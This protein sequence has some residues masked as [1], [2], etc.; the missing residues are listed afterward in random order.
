MK[1]KMKKI[2]TFI[3]AIAMILSFQ[4]SAFADEL[5]VNA[6]QTET[7]T[8]EE[9]EL[10]VLADSITGTFPIKDGYELATIRYYTDAAK[11]SYAF[12]DFTESASGYAYSFTAPYSGFSK[13]E[14]VETKDSAPS[15][16]ATVIAYYYSTT[17]WDGAVDVSWY[18]PDA[19]EYYITNPAEFA[20]VAAIVN[21]SLDVSVK[22]YMVKGERISDSEKNPDYTYRFDMKYIVSQW[23]ENQSAAAGKTNDVYMGLA[24]NDFSDKV[25]Y[26]TENLDMGGK[27]GDEFNISFDEEKYTRLDESL[28]NWMPIGGFF[29]ADIKDTRTQVRAYFNGQFDG[30]GHSIDNLYCFRWNPWY[31]GMNYAA[32]VK[33]EDEFCAYGY[34]EGVGLFGTIASLYDNEETPTIAP[35][36]RNL[37]LS[38]LTT[39]RRRQGAIIGCVNGYDADA[40]VC[41]ENCANH[42][43]VYN[44]D[45]FGCAGIIGDSRTSYSNFHVSVINCY[46]T[47]DIYAD[48]KCLAAGIVSYNENADIIC[49]YNS[50]NIS[51]NGNKLGRQIGSDSSGSNYTISDTYYVH[52]ASYDDPDSSSGSPGYFN[53]SIA[54][55]SSIN[56]TK[57]VEVSQKE[58]T[59][60]TLL[61]YLNVNGTA[62]VAGAD[63][64]PVLWFEADNAETEYTVTVEQPNEGGTVTANVESGSQVK[65]GT[66]VRLNTKEES[67]WNFK[68][69]TLND[70][71]LT[72]DYVTVG[73]D[74]NI[75]AVIKSA[76]A[77]ILNIESN[78]Y[79]DI[80]VT[81]T[82]I[83]KKDGETIQVEKYPVSDGDSIYQKD[84]LFVTVSL[85]EGAIPDDPNYE[86]MAAAGLA[87]PYNYSFVY[88]NGVSKT[89]RQDNVFDVDANIDE[90]GAQLTLTVTPLT[91][92]K[93]WTTLADTSWYDS[94]STSFT[95]TT[96]AELAGLDKLVEEGNT[97][98]GKTIKLGADIG[99]TNT[100]GTDGERCWNGIGSS[101]KDDTTSETVYHAFEGTFDG[102]GHSITNYSGVS[103]GLFDTCIGSSE[104]NP[105]VIKN[106]SVYGKAIGSN[107][108]GILGYGKN[109]TIENCNSYVVIDT[110]ETLKSTNHLG[111][112]VA[113]GLDGTKIENCVNYGQITGCGYLGGIAGY[114]NTETS[115][116]RCINTGNIT[117]INLASYGGGVFGE[118]DGAVDQC[119]NYGTVTS[120]A[121]G[122]V[123]NRMGGFAGYTSATTKEEITNSYNA[124]KL[125]DEGGSTNLRAGG[126]IGWGNRFIVSNCFN[127]GRVLMNSDSNSTYYGS[128]MGLTGKNSS[129]QT[130]NVYLLDSSSDKSAEGKTYDEIDKTK[131]YYQGITLSTAEKFKNSNYVLK[132]IN[133]D[134]CF[135]LVSD[136]PELSFVAERVH[137]HSGGEATCSTQAVC[138]VCGLYYGELDADNHEDIE[139][140]QNAYE[141]RWNID[142]YTGDTVCLACGK[143]LEKGEAIEPDTSKTAITLSIYSGESK[144]TAKLLY[145]RELTVAEFDSMKSTETVGYQYG[146]YTEG[147][148][149]SVIMASSS[150]VTLDTIL[151]ECNYTLDDIYRF[152]VIATG[153]S[154]DSIERFK[155][156]PEKIQSSC[157][158][159]NEKGEKI[160][161]PIA[162]AIDH[163]TFDTPSLEEAAKYTSITGNLRLG[164]GVS[165]EEFES[166]DSL[167]G[168]KLIEPIKAVELYVKEGSAETSISLDKTEANL[169]CGGTLKLNATVKGKVTEEVK[170]SSSDESVATVDNDGNVTGLK[171]GE[172]TIT[173]K[174]GIYKAE[175]KVKVNLAPQTITAKAAK[176]TV[177]VGK[178]DKI[179]VSGAKTSVTY[180]SSKTSIATVSAKGVITAKAPGT[181]TITVTAAATDQYKAATK[182]VKVKV[183]PKATK[184]SSAK[185]TASKKVT[186][187]W[188]KVAGV[189]G[190]QIKYVTGKTTKT[191]TV[192]G[193]AKVKKVLTKLKK[194]KTYKIY[195]RTY[196]TVSK[197]NYYSSW[198][199]VKKVKI[200]K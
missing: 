190:Y 88:T 139:E 49:C 6:V 137:K 130:K 85:K 125:I 72:S 97:F 118:V 165:E 195:V 192:K 143:I 61:N 53:G 84:R 121:E 199:A 51:T 102:Q 2:I 131:T 110:S 193:A 70:K 166:G 21:G 11:T 159:F 25:I 157:Y 197:T 20:G 194:G 164:V 15:S 50:G 80:T 144:D 120:L 200:K 99:L 58:A 56:F 104:S 153:N 136:Y 67:G 16:D 37:S 149:Y 34:T 73:Q 47:G 186:V 86:F 100:D 106:V 145:Q 45:K 91:T 96:A 154:T 60:G 69:Y 141:P 9:V 160:S 13:V 76:A 191:V 147:K 26:L 138:E 181:V 101:E 65:C 8:E 151:K 122:S 132:K 1:D 22:D 161:A 81:K 68:Y 198:S 35:A 59:D 150:Y 152:N 187:K 113:Y 66:I 14:E 30:C 183:L 63:G 24:E 31:S 180:K 87:N 127:Y 148:G 17:K 184:I 38:G 163:G 175:C 142:G 39:G 93:L 77:G 146:S 115:V 167:G 109:V 32:G 71:K 158:F 116:S 36:I 42:A 5:D 48:I 75:Q 185:N 40:T 103:N 129:N 62:F 23:L 98:K 28:P 135:T 74:S 29:L 123:M 83:I 52:K 54:E 156:T 128:F 79:I 78:K 41:V 12:A 43:Y 105:T 179:T 46:N 124:G 133:K 33:S 126:F 182:T 140:G 189:T 18:D 95:L 111:G 168:N 178:T 112:I 3:L 171:S 134:S 162:I 174:L 64:S 82:G 155:L 173:A 169:N 119:A 94:K 170:W 57:P 19:S 188:K 10:T 92:P 107:A 90:E 89:S 44:T 55:S 4:V 114:L 117:L 177:V 108:S 176:S 196:K 27:D 172:V 7:E